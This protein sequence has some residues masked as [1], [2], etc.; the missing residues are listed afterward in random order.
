MGTGWNAWIMLPWSRKTWAR[1]MSN[2]WSFST[3]STLM[4]RRTQI[5]LPSSSVSIRTKLSRINNLPS[6]LS[7]RMPPPS[8]LRPL[9]SSGS[10]KISLWKR[11]RRNRRTKKQASKELSPDK[12][13]LNL[14]STSSDL[15]IS[16][17]P[18][19]TL[20]KPAKNKWNSENN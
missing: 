12:S 8:R 11:S 17:M 19:L 4:M 14:S 2:C 18:T 10:A 6:S 7:S 9:R 20:W 15:L 5:T 13:R 3:R 16:L 1:M